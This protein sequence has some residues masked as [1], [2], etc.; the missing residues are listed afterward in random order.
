V[1]LHAALSLLPSVG[2]PHGI[3]HSFLAS[4]L[5]DGV[6]YL[7]TCPALMELENAGNLFVQVAFACFFVLMAMAADLAG[8]PEDEASDQSCLSGMS[9]EG[10]VSPTAENCRLSGGHYT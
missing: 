10:L 3:W 2:M 4:R 7:L 5:F 8:D 6:R 1:E 9:L